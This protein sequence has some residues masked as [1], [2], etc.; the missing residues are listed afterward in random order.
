MKPQCKFCKSKE[1]LYH[2]CIFSTDS[3]SSVS[4][5]ICNKC[6]KKE[7]VIEKL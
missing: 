7:K 5:H 6:Y 2:V 4:H 3:K 1:H